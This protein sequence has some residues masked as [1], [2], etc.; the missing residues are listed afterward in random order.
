MIG[1]TH[2]R[3]AGYVVLLLITATSFLGSFL[4]ARAY[5]DYDTTNCRWAYSGGSTFKPKHRMGPNNTP[6]GIY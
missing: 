6:T 3:V 2:H 1:M 4:A 5:N